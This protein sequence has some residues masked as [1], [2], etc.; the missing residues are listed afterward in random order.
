MNLHF[1]SED[2][3]DNGACLL[4]EKICTICLS[5][6]VPCQPISIQHLQC[7]LSREFLGAHNLWEFY[8]TQR[9]LTVTI[10]VTILTEQEEHASPESSHFPLEPKFASKAYR[11][12]WHSKKHEQWGNL[13]VPFHICVTFLFKLIT[14][15][16][17]N[18]TEEKGKTG[19]PFHFLIRAKI[20]LLE[21]VHI[22]IWN[23]N[24]W[25][26]FV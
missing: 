12:K 11:W 18:G 8:K 3:G 4:A 16:A 15:T 2:W 7:S 1:S 26:S 23:I 20:V 5:I 9:K 19:H 24:S 21:C 25:V 6:T 13:M 14:Y 10:C 17:N 22:K